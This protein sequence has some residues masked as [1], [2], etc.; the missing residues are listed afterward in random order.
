MAILIGLYTVTWLPAFFMIWLARYGHSTVVYPVLPFI[1]LSCD[2][3][4]SQTGEWSF[5]FAYGFGMER[6]FVIRTWQK[7]MKDHLAHYV[8]RTAILE[9]R[10]DYNRWPIDNTNELGEVYIYTNDWSVA[11]DMRHSGDNKEVFGCLAEGNALKNP[12][13]KFYI[14]ETRFLYDMNSN[15]IN[16]EGVP[17]RVIIDFQTN[18]VKVW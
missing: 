7:P 8:L 11:P 10:W 15:L 18:D 5:Y 17:Y 6:L 2:K 16:N 12:N 14:E 4:P 1:V 9:Y 13:G 3:Y